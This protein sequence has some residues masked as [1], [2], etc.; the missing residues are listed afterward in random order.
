MLKPPH[1]QYNDSIKARFDAW[2][3]EKTRLE[4][5]DLLAQAEDIIEKLDNFFY[6]ANL[7]EEEKADRLSAGD[8]DI[9]A[10]F[11]GCADYNPD[12]VELRA[13]V[14]AICKGEYDREKYPEHPDRYDGDGLEPARLKGDLMEKIGCEYEDHVLGVFLEMN[15][16]DIVMHSE[17]YVRLELFYE[18]LRDWLSG[19]EMDRGSLLRMLNLE[20]ALNTVFGEYEGSG[21]AEY[22]DLEALPGF[23]EFYPSSQPPAESDLS[24]RF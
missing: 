18:E 13:V 4:P 11:G 15:Q 12:Y 24:L 21:L 20:N 17:S 14:E 22:I 10:P 2:L 23:A 8:L 1:E 5:A 9:G 16:T 6:V 19:L 3:A 7:T